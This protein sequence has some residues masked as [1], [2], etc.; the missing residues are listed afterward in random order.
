MIYHTTYG[1]VTKFPKI[2]SSSAFLSGGSKVI[3]GIIA[4]KEGEPGNE[5]TKSSV[6]LKRSQTSDARVK[7]M[8]TREEGLNKLLDVRSNISN[9]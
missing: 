3:H 4:W 7:L 8:Y 6:L 2:S 9:V 1:H 5:A